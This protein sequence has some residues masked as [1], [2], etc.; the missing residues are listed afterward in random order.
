MKPRI[1]RSPSLSPFSSLSAATFPMTPAG[2]T[3]AQHE[4][5]LGAQR[6]DGRDYGEG[7][8]G[9]VPRRG[10]EEAGGAHGQ[11]VGRRRSRRR[12][13]CRPPRASPPRRGRPGGRGPGS[14]ASRKA[15]R[16]GHSRANSGVAPPAR[17][18]K[19]PAAS[20]ARGHPA[21][22]PPAPPAAPP[23]AARSGCA[24]WKMTRHASGIGRHIR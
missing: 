19:R 16:A 7:D 23:A 24:E 13:G 21:P 18:F 10:V 22:A 17:R 20:A 14:T 9:G 3:D 4:G 1:Y 8:G 11:D 15:S 12:R 6:D 5:D 2:Q